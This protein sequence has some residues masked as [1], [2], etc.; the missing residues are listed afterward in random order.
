MPL[1][2]C[3]S[4]DFNTELP[5]AWVILAVGGQTGKIAEFKVQS[6]RRPAQIP[7]EALLPDHLPALAEKVT[8]RIRSLRISMTPRHKLVA[9]I[10]APP[11]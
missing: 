7:T 5:S 3:G 10:E 8:R 1:N 9:R 6:P 11:S 4:M 2:V